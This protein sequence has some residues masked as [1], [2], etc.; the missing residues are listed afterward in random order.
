ML[1]L[2]NA[3]SSTLDL[4]SGFLQVDLEESSWSYTA[5]TTSFGQ[6]MFKRM[7]Q[8]LRNLPLTFKKL[9][10]SLLLGLIGTSVFCI[11]D[12]VIIAS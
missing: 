12:D 2:G 6:F 10:K 3:V 4:H 7:A 9:M 1:R 11:L 8:S 5:F